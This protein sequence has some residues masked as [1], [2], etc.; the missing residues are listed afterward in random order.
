MVKQFGVYA[1]VVI[2][3]LVFAAIAG[4]FLIGKKIGKGAPPPPPKKLP[5]NGSGIPAGFSAESVAA[6][7]NDVLSGWFSSDAEKLALIGK[8]QGYSDD[9]LTA[10]YNRFN[11]RYGRGESL[12]E[13]FK[14]EW[15][16]M[17]YR[18]D[19]ELLSR[20]RNLELT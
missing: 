1:Y 9:Q 4:I 8:L 11:E 13:W 7:I 2:S 14:S 19:D 6:E 15:S 16:L 5:N 18:Q 17:A 12:Y 10:V 20:M 3:V